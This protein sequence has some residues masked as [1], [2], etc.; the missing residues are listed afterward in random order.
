M[1]L[2]LMIV[3]KMQIS[4]AILRRTLFPWHQWRC[5]TG[6]SRCWQFQIFKTTV[7]DQTWF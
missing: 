3:F 6:V 1:L 5:P 2:K 7:K 4:T